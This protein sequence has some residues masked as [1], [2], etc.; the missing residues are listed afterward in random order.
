MEEGE[1]QEQR[2]QSPP[3]LA[4]GESLMPVVS[5]SLGD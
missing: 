4:A 1:R 3:S 2:A 5:A